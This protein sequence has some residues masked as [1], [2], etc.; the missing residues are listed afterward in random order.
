[1]TLEELEIKVIDWA[2]DKQIFSK[3]TRSKQ[4][5]KTQEEVTELKE[6]I[7]KIEFIYGKLNYPRNKYLTQIEIDAHLEIMDAIG[8]IILTLII[9][10]KMNGVNIQRCLQLAYEEIK[11]R[12]GEMKNGTFVK[13]K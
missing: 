4:F 7:T 9:Q 5:D 11:D 10:A 6:A 8:D 13:D 2:E 3:A 1:M 12:T